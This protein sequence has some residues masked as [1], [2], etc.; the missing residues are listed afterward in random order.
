ML[1]EVHLLNFSPLYSCLARWG[2]CTKPIWVTSDVPKLFTSCEPLLF[3]LLYKTEA[4]YISVCIIKSHEQVF[5]TEILMTH[6][7]QV[8]AHLHKTHKTGG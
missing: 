2:L 5:R 6:E 1:T 3:Y 7:T 8:S 4:L